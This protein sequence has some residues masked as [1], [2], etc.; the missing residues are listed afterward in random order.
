MI[1]FK[2][3]FKSGTDPAAPDLNVKHLQYI[4]TRPGAVRNQGCGFGLWGRMPGQGP[5]RDI[6]DLRQARTEIREASKRRTVYRAIVSMEG[7][8]AAEKGYY[9]RKSWERLL[10]NHVSAI[11]KEMDIR[12]ENFCWMASMHYAK[13]HPHVHLVYW[14]NGTDPRPEFVSR[15][16]FDIMAEHIRAEFGREV[17][18]E[19]LKQARAEQQSEIKRL[20]LELRAMCRDANPEAALNLQKLE[21]SPLT[22]QLADRLAELVR[23][24]P[25][26]GSLD[27]KL[28]PPECKALVDD[29]AKQ[30]LNAPELQRQLDLFR[31]A[32]DR[33]SALYGNGGETAAR[34]RDKAEA[35]LGRELGNEIMNA[36][37][38]LTRELKGEH[39]EDRAE[40]AK[41]LSGDA[42]AVARANPAYQTLLA[43]MPPERIPWSE[44]EK[45]IP[46]W[47]AAVSRIVKETA[48]DYRLR[49]R[50]RGYVEGEIKAA[51]AKPGSDA[52]RALFSD[53][54]GEVYRQLR[55]TVTEA[56]REDAGWSAEAA[57]TC[58]LG[59]LCGVMRCV[60]QLTGQRSAQVSRA[61][62]AGKLR[63]RD[64]SREAKKDYLATQAQA[65]DWELE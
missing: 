3:W 23:R 56:L 57:R 5:P 34:N 2:Q 40:L 19:E 20:R 17:Y 8:E 50:V 47:E 4:A 51:G 21:K 10:E 32:T 35:A 15:E 26:S 49:F 27:Y 52:A 59:M 11:A 22:Q 28:L 41:L 24:L 65:G 43:A 64:M 9:D 54:Y 55:Q 7:K 37:R 36:V 16:R 29:L 14:D 53:A 6:L 13:G 44:M 18:R 39:P 30:C 61:R 25:P 12:P 60:S 45:Q 62:A 31:K 48:E 46:G 42:A 33:I 58:A 1:V 38:E 63:S